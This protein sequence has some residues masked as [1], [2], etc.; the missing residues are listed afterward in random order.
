MKIRPN[1]IVNILIILAIIII[2]GLTWANYQYTSQHPGGNDFLSRWVGTRYFLLKGQSP[3]SQ[4]TT[5]AI[6]QMM[7]GRAAKP[8]EDQVLFVYPFFSIF[9]FA[10]FSIIGNY[11]LARALWMTTLE[12]AIFG[13]AV[14][15]ISLSRWKIP[16]VLLI[17]FL[18]FS[19]SWYY[20]IRPIINGNVA[21]ICALAM[22]GIFLAIRS[23]HDFLA[24]LLMA[25]TMVK[26]QMVILLIP[27][28]I[29]WAITHQRW[30]IVWGFLGCLGLLVATSMLFIKDWIVQNLIQVLSYPNYTLPGTP[31]A[32]FS[33]WLPGIGKQMGW[34]LTGLLLAILIWEW[35]ISRDKDF[36]WFFWT[37]SLTIVATNLIGIRTATEN[38]IAMLPALVLV[39]HLF[40]ERWRVVGRVF[41]ILSILTLFGGVWFI[42]IKTLQPGNQPIQSPIM[43]F[44]LPVYLLVGLYWVRWWAINPPRLLL[45]QFRSKYNEIIE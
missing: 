3:Y 23:N 27:Y 38:Y 16:R 33:E 20:G 9:I 11:A 19:I 14:I 40:D 42:F 25:I 4:E 35:I 12:L 10:P 26:P 17:L 5:N 39:F 37:S 1:F 15:S 6:Q 18:V 34:G 8:D 41:V 44:I 43:F 36:N 7:Y 22:G 21:V 13:L 30:T 29:I 28:L 45:E 32:I 2:I 31:G 24:G